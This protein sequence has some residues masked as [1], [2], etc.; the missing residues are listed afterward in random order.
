MEYRRLKL[1]VGRPD[2]LTPFFGVFD[3]EPGELGRCHWHRHS[4]DI[5]NS[6]PEP[7]LGVDN[8]C[9]D[10]HVE[11][12]NDPHWRVLGSADTDPADGLITWQEFG[13]GWGIRQGS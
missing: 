13:D 11:L 5:V 9:V 12:V 8:G 10:F 1:D 2:E 3:D 6:C 4:A 7:A